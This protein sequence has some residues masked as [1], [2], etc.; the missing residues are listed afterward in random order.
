MSGPERFD[1]AEHSA[2]SL[3]LRRSARCLSRLARHVGIQA[4]RPLA[5]GRLSC[6]LGQTGEPAHSQQR[7]D[8]GEDQHAGENASKCGDE[9]VAA[10]PSPV[11]FRRTDLPG[12]DRFPAEIAPDVRREVTRGRVPLLLVFRE[13]LGHDDRDVAA[14]MLVNRAQ[15][16]RFLL[17]DHPCN[18]V[19]RKLIEMVR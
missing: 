3:G 17:R 13:R 2:V 12:Q 16:C 7:R 18:L 5:L 9:P 1:L 8:G 15:R 10:G 6:K 11:S 14:V 19:H 4:C